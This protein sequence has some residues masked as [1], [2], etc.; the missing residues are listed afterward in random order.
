MWRKRVL[1]PYV[2]SEMVSML[3]G[4]VDGGTGIEATIPGYTVAG[5]TGTAQK[6]NGH[7]GY[8]NQYDGSFIGFLPAE[9]PQVEIMIVV[10]SPKTS[11]FGGDVAAPAFEQIGSWYANHAGIKPDRPVN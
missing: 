10:D 8:S 6:P 3:E 11:H 2:D 1:S 7:G 9:N 4:V 5:K